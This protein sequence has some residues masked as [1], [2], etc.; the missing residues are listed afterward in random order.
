MKPLET[1]NHPGFFHILGYDTI[2]IS[3]DGR[4]VDL[5]RGIE[6]N[7]L[8]PS[9]FYAGVFTGTTYVHVHRLLALAFIDCLG[10]YETMQVN[11]KDGNKLNNALDN[12]EWVTISQNA[13]HAYMT[14]LRTDNRPIDVIDLVDGTESHHYSLQDCARRFKVNGGKIHGYLHGNRRRALAKRFALKYANESWGDLSS[15]TVG[16]NPTGQGF[17]RNV[18]ALNKATNRLVIFD[19]VS[20]MARHLGFNEGAVRYH[21]NLPRDSGMGE[22][23]F[24]YYDN[25]D[26]D[27]SLAERVDGLKKVEKPEA[28]KRKPVPIRVTNSIDGSSQEWP[29]TEAFALSAG[30]KKN[31]LQKAILVNGGM[32]RDF[33]VEYLR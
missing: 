17:A 28:W 30:V 19:A 29:S 13:L 5:V 6:L 3:K 20:T 10:A 23:L 26:G 7:V 22:W 16:V 2:A 24:Y 1:Q 4:V 21:L 25:F 32:W 15:I 12:L 9:D 27:T 14:G 31:T 8:K 11:H 33:Q 18:V